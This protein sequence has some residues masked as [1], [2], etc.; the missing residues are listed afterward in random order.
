MDISVHIALNFPLNE[1]K[2]MP[3]VESLGV[4]KTGTALAGR[5]TK[6]R[7]TGHV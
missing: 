6:Q 7:V 1:M 3:M 4:G 5:T 2:V